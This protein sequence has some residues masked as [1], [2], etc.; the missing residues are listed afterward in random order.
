M[1]LEILGEICYSEIAGEASLARCLLITNPWEIH[2][3]QRV[4]YHFAPQFDGS[5][6]QG[7][8][9]GGSIWPCGAEF[10]WLNANASADPDTVRKIR[11]RPKT[12]I[13]CR[14]E[15]RYWPTTDNHV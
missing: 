4:S 3:N 14:A 7:Q 10:S 9:G 2:K 13:A 6:P 12:F 1:S 5:R 8:I 11:N 15:V